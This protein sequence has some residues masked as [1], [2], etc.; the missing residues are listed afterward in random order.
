[1]L[2]GGN[3]VDQLRLLRGGPLLAIKHLPA[4]VLRLCLAVLQGLPWDSDALFHHPNHAVVQR[5]IGDDRGRGPRDEDQLSR[6]P[7]LL[8]LLLPRRRLLD[9]EEDQDDERSRFS[10]ALCASK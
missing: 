8:P 3:T 10:N 2:S 9:Q 7:L 1:M 4:K 6:I 5:G